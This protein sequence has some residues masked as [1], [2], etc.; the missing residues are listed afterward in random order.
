M[1]QATV[2]YLR[3]SGSAK[4]DEEDDEEEDGDKKKLKDQLSGK[5]YLFCHTH[6]R[7]SSVRCNRS[8]KAQRQVGRHC[9]I[10]SGQGSTEGKCHHASQV[11]ISLHWYVW[12]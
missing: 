4:K 1:K 10:A 12:R 2:I 6:K 7:V 8:E 9:R 11:S 5:A 3:G